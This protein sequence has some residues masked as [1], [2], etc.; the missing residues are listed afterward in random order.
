MREEPVGVGFTC[1]R[2]GA[3]A[4][5]GIRPALSERTESSEE[6][7]REV[8]SFEKNIMLPVKWSLV[9]ISVILVWLINRAGIRDPILY[10]SVGS[11][12]ATNVAFSY[13]FCR[14]GALKGIRTGAYLSLVADILFFS[15]LIYV[16]EGRRS[17]LY[18][19]YCMLMIRASANFP[20]FKVQ[21][22]TLVIFFFAYFL[23]IFLFEGR[24]TFLKDRLFLIRVVF[25]LG[26]AASSGGIA[27]L[28]KKHWERRE[29]A[30]EDLRKAEDR[31]VRSERLAAVGRLAAGIAHGLKNPLATITNCSFYLKRHLGK[32][33]LS[34]RKQ[35]DILGEEVSRCDKLITDLLNYSQPRQPKLT[36]TDINQYLEEALSRQCKHGETVPILRQHCSIVTDLR[37]IKVQKDFSPLPSILVDSEQIKEA[38][39]NVIRNSLEAMPDGGT[40]R[41][42]STFNIKPST[43]EIS[44]TD[45]GCGIPENVVGKVFEPFYSTK[46]KGSGLGLFITHSIIESHKGSCEAESKVGRGTTI[47]IRLP[48]SHG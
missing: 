40:L 47:T 24:F 17:E 34:T 30:L 15:A 41:I 43:I 2:E 19:V 8:L 38:F 9:L 3:C 22:P 21:G 4:S 18:L 5:K 42:L 28:V 7:W 6:R 23:A 26:I 37:K 1:A 46:E 10:Y 39:S 29:I 14:R 27:N 12:L 31:L 25:L 13:L 11:Y 48:V 20:S 33:A 36:R 32:D 44:F 16:T 35:I 45:S